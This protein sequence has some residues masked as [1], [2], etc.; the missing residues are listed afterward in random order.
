M[1]L[2]THQ[3]EVLEANGAPVM[4][5]Y[6]RE[7]KYWNSLPSCLMTRWLLKCANSMRPKLMWKIAKSG[8]FCFPPSVDHRLISVYRCFFGFFRR[9]IPSCLYRRRLIYLKSYLKQ[10][11]FVLF[12]FCLVELSRPKNSNQQVYLFFGVLY[13]K[14]SCSLGQ[15]VH[16]RK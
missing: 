15:P 7:E 3:S 1:D 12:F 8:H 10:L 11:K 6:F 9:S 5:C 2:E 4:M 13:F 14:R 16:C